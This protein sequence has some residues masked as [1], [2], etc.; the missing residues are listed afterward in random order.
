MRP[1]NSIGRDRQ[2]SRLLQ[3]RLPAKLSEG[4]VEAAALTSL[5]AALR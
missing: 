2:T 1:G 4:I 5:K 3:D